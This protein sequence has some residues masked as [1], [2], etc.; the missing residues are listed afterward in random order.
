[1]HKDHIM[2]INAKQQ[3]LSFELNTSKEVLRESKMIW[4]FL[5]RIKKKSLLEENSKRNEYMCSKKGRV[6]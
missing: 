6:R 1:M 3:Q 4:N 2:I 5:L